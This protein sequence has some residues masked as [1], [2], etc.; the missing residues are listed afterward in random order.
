MLFLH[1]PTRLYLHREAWTSTQTPFRAHDL[2]KIQPQ[3]AAEDGAG[4]EE[5]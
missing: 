1:F 3:E 2:V 4:L 5:A